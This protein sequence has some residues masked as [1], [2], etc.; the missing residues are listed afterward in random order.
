MR[1]VQELSLNS[2][3]FREMRAVSFVNTL[4]DQGR[5]ISGKKIL[6]HEIEAEDAL[7]ELTNTSKMNA[8]WDFLLRLHRLIVSEQAVGAEAQP[9]CICHYQHPQYGTMSCGDFMGPFTIGSKCGCGY[10]P[11]HH[12]GTCAQLIDRWG[13]A[14]R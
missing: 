11:N 12:T 5:M 8:D 14:V 1:R 3:L 4:V 7:G 9:G 6:V 2:S 13:H 10:N